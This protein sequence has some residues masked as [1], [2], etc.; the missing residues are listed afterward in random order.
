MLSSRSIALPV[1]VGVYVRQQHDDF[2]ARRLEVDELVG[3]EHVTDVEDAGGLVAQA[4]PCD[5]ADEPFAA[6]L[7]TSHAARD[8]TGTGDDEDADWPQSGDER[9]DEPQYPGH[10]VFGCI[11]Y[12]A[13]AGVTA[14]RFLECLAA[15]PPSVGHC[16]L[17]SC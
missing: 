6:K 1:E 7:N 17:S 5:P 10:V 3:G 13:N 8:P 11:A 2:E 16:Y 4:T 12:R 14:R 9:R 15:R